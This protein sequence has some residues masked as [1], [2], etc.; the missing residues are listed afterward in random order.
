MVK[1]SSVTERL[2]GPVVPLNICFTDDDEVD[3]PTMRKYVNWLC[4]QKVP[5][6]LLTYGSSEYYW[7]SDDD[8]WRLTAELAEE[9]AG[10][11]L[12]ITS[13]AWWPPKVCRKFLKH[14]E[15]SG[16]DAVKVQINLGIMIKAGPAKVEVFRSYHDQVQ[17]ASPIPLL[18][19]CNSK[20]SPI[21]VERSTRNGV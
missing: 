13:T 2:K 16:A 5:V 20:G 15:K 1:K 12:F 10:R 14:A 19:W 18:L 9:T 6:L 8:I 7:L 3:F 21:P 11:S 4:E 17:D